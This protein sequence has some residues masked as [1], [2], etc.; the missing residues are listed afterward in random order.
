M[1]GDFHGTTHSSHTTAF[2]PKLWP[3]LIAKEWA[4]SL[5]DLLLPQVQDIP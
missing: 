2:R 4:K 5:I 1:M 3:W